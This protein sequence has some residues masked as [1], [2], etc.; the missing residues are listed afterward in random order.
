M[1]SQQSTTI[2]EGSSTKSRILIEAAK[3]NLTLT[4]EEMLQYA[5]SKLN[6][7]YIIK[8]EISDKNEFES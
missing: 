8:R 5:L 6:Y 2:F 4:F 1:N 3:D 7:Q